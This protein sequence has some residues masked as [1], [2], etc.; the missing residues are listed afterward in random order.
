MPYKYF[1]IV[2][3]NPHI[4]LGFEGCQDGL[5]CDLIGWQNDAGS[6]ARTNRHRESLGKAGSSHRS[7]STIVGYRTKESFTLKSKTGSYRSSRTRNI[8]ISDVVSC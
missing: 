4:S 6:D 7:L 8:L 3:K 2:Y 1:R 5:N